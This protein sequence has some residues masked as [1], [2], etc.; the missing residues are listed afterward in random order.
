MREWWDEWYNKYVVVALCVA[1]GYGGYHSI[2]WSNVDGQTWAAWVQAIGAT[3][4]IAIAIAVPH[5]QQR[6]AEKREVAREAEA[7][8]HDLQSILDELEVTFEGLMRT[9]GKT[10]VED[11]PYGVYHY[12]F[13]PDLNGCV[14][15]RAI[16]DRLG[17][18]P[19]RELRRRIV[20]TY[21]LLEGILLDF[22]THADLWAEFKA[23]AEKT[24]NANSTQ[25]AMAHGEVLNRLRQISEAL[26]TSFIETTGEMESLIKDLKVYLDDVGRRV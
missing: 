3:V 23:G 10:I 20:R 14:I 19:K 5:A 18:I 22:H 1:I 6:W 15:Y 16:S 17:R 25:A 26:R 4:G 12:A 13:R 7:V 2:C 11:F 9:A 21:G 8:K 24:A